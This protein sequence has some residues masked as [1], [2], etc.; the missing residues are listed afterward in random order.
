MTTFSSALVQLRTPFVLSGGVSLTFFIPSFIL[1]DSCVEN[2]VLVPL[3]VLN[4][5]APWMVET[6]IPIF[7]IVFLPSNILDGESNLTMTK[8]RVSLLARKWSPIVI[9]RGISP[10]DQDFS[11]ENPISGTFESILDALMEVWTMGAS[12][13]VAPLSFFPSTSE[14]TRRLLEAS[15]YLFCSKDLSWAFGQTREQSVIRSSVRGEPIPVVLSSV[16]VPG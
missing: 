1:S 2:T 7:C 10:L 9:S 16:I 11:P 14:H 12:V 5:M 6:T 15:S 13:G 3:A 4:L 8:L